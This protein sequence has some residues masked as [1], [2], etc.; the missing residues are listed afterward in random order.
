MTKHSFKSKVYTASDILEM[1]HTSLCG[2]IG[3]KSYYGDQYF[4]LFM[5]EYSRMIIVI[6]LKVK[7]DAFPLFKW[8]LA[9]VQK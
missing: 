7:Y 1:V 2:L 6:F 8:Y 5:D 4:I 9:R 3:V